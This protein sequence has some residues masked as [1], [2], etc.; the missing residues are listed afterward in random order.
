MDVRRIRIPCSTN[1]VHNELDSK[2][3]FVSDNYKLL[4][5]VQKGWDIYVNL[6]LALTK[7][8]NR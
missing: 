5:V 7:T 4:L 6:K 1:Q 3:E 8:V 2:D